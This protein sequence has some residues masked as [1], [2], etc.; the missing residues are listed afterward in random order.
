MSPMWRAFSV[1]ISARHPFSRLHNGVRRVGN[2]GFG[3]RKK[4]SRPIADPDLIG[5]G[6]EMLLRFKAERPRVPVIMITD[7]GDDATRKRATELGAA[8]LLS[9][10]PLTLAYSGK[11]SM[12]GRV[13][14]VPEGATEP[15]QLRKISSAN[16]HQI[17][18][19]CSY[20]DPS[21]RQSLPTSGSPGNIPL[22]RLR[23]RRR[24]RIANNARVVS[25]GRQWKTT[26]TVPNSPKSATAVW[27]MVGV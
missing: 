19:F 18:I 12:R 17:A 2:A 4:H 26:S 15:S 16:Q 11:K 21:P 24:H 14:V 3:T 6:L 5:C 13:S 10:S 20:L 25:D 27:P 8:G 23:P 7:Q 9:L 1:A 22:I